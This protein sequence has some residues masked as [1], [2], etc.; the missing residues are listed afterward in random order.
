MDARGS[1]TR[2]D[3][4]LTLHDAAVWIYELLHPRLANERSVARQFSNFGTARLD[5]TAVY[6]DTP[7]VDTLTLQSRAKSS[8]NRAFLWLISPY[9]DHEI[10]DG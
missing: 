3:L 9:V 4:A 7:D 5:Q 6:D 2:N 1:P 8:R 10:L